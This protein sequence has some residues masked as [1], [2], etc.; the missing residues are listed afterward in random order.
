[1]DYTTDEI[2]AEY[3]R[4]RAYSTNC[5]IRWNQYWAPPIF[6]V[7]ESQGS[8]PAI[9]VPQGHFE[10]EIP[11]KYVVLIQKCLESDPEVLNKFLALAIG[12]EA[13][14]QRRATKPAPRR[15]LVS[16]FIDKNSIDN[17]EFEDDCSF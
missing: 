13:N 16:T 14:T 10:V 5:A 17:I 3:A 11:L 7:I 15:R 2:K 4:T 6:D 12:K 1:M 9:I 8:G